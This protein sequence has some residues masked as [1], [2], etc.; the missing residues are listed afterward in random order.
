MPVIK[1]RSVNKPGSLKK[2]A[3]LT[4]YLDNEADGYNTDGLTSA[5]QTND[6][7]PGEWSL[8]LRPKADASH[9]GRV[10]TV[11]D[12]ETIMA[13]ELG[14]FLA[15]FLKYPSH[16]SLAASVGVVTPAEREAWR[17]GKIINPK[18]DYQMMD[19]AIAGYDHDYGEHETDVRCIISDMKGQKDVNTDVIERLEKTLA[20][21]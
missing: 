3:T 14:H 20:T 6:P 19:A 16:D 7:V 10:L 9:M 8:V 17:I 5:F 1:S 12:G 21:E 13:H 11:K 4:I 2:L 15:T 18:L